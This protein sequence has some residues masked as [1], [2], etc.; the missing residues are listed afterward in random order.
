MQR[1]RQGCRRYWPYVLSGFVF[2]LSVVCHGGQGGQMQTMEVLKDIE[3]GQAGGQSLLLDIGMPAGEQ[4][5]PGIILVHGGGWSGGDKQDMSFLFKPLNDAGFVCFSINYRLAPEYRWPACLDDVLTSIRWVK[6]HGPEY[7]ADPQRLAI[8][9][10][11]AGGHLA[12]MAAVEAGESEGVAAVVGIAAPTDHEADSQRRGGL[13]PSLQKLLDRSTEIDEESR[14]ILR[15]I[16][17]ITYIKPKLPPFFL[18]HGTEDTSVPYAQSVSLQAKLRD[19][20]VTCELF[21]LQGATIK[22]RIGL[23]ITRAK[24]LTGSVRRWLFNRK[25]R[26]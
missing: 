5:R 21:T 18:I 22:S 8:L 3:Y 24:W 11:S 19:N 16:S 20:Q 15:Q 4:R 25:T 23:R 7:N 9:G 2:G 12:C 6:E 17:P 13:S 10:Y 14:Q 26:R 1:V